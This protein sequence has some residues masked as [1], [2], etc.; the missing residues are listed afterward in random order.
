MGQIRVKYDPYYMGHTASPEVICFR[1]PI[2]EIIYLKEF[3][4]FLERMVEFSYSHLIK[5]IT[6][7]KNDRS[8]C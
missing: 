6:D 7:C 1:S 5:V 4:I 2:H 3:I 8:G